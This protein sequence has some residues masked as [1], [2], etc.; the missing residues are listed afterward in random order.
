[1]K[2]ISKIISTVLLIFSI[3]LLCYTFYR[4]QI[5]HEGTKFNYYLKYYIISFLFLGLSLVSFFISEKLKKDIATICFSTLIALY[6]VEGYLFIKDKDNDDRYVIYKNNTGKDYDRRTKLEIYQ[7]LKK[8]DPNIVVTIR[9]RNLLDD[10]NLNYFILSGISNR[11]TINCNENGYYSIFQSDRYGFNNPDEEWDKNVVDFFLVGD[12]IVY[13]YC[14][15][16]SDT[17]SGNLRK[18]IDNKN[19]VIN[20]GGGN[21]GSLIEYATLREYL[22]IKKVERVLWVYNDSDLTQLGRELKNQI[23]VNYLQDK[24]FSQN[25]ILR[26]QEIQKLLLKKLK[27]V[28]DG[29]NSI[30]FRF[31]KLYSTRE[32][33]LVIFN[34]IKHYF[35]TPAPVP[36]EEFK[37]I[38]KLSNKLT[39]KNNSKLYFVYL[40]LY[41]RYAVEKQKYDLQLY[42]EVIEIV[43]SLNIPIIDL[44]EE[45]FKKYDDPLSLFP[46]RKKG[47][48]T[49]KGNQLVAETIF[50]KINEF[51]K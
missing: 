18:L 42:K 2:S 33:I 46:F 12:S 30:T 47:H 3:L 19:G 1:M 45:L 44:H 17:I 11:K 50:N 10:N 28:G 14:V 49:E 27:Q 5:F 36:T 26:K 6:F 21:N 31:I 13:G 43:E 34:K 20:V 37:N 9:P 16:E 38:L 48:Y 40:P 4:S 22:P 24:S 51:E 39:K 41:S 8:E 23:L 15:N 29:L 32:V 25:A 35:Y 7:D